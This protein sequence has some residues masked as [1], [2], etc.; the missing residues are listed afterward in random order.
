MID[1]CD[2]SDWDLTPSNLHETWAY[3]TLTELS[4]DDAVSILKNNPTTY[5]EAIAYARGACLLFHLENLLDFLL[6]NESEDNF[7]AAYA[8]IKLICRDEPENQIPNELR[9]KFELGAKKIAE[10]QLSYGADIDIYGNFMEMYS[11]Y[12]DHRHD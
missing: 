2:P 8:Y 7:A 11:K 9:E 1:K 10:R 3:K 12:I 6:N 5:T 4:R